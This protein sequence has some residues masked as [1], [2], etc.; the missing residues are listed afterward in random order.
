MQ[1]FDVSTASLG[2]PVQRAWLGSVSVKRCSCSQCHGASL[3]LPPARTFVYEAM[4]CMDMVCLSWHKHS[5]AQL[6]V[7]DLMCVG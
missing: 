6:C 7:E 4:P 5:A 1:M 2:L 3:T